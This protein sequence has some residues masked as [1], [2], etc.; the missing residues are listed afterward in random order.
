MSQDMLASRLSAKRTASFYVLNESALF[1]GALTIGGGAG[2]PAALLTAGLL[3]G[4]SW[5]TAAIG[6][7]LCGSF[8]G[9]HAALLFDQPG[10]L[11]ERK[12][13]REDLVGGLVSAFL[14][15]AAFVFTIGSTALGLQ[16][17][18]EGPYLQLVAWTVYVVILAFSL[19]GSGS[20]RYF[21]TVLIFLL[22]RNFSARPSKF[23]SW[24]RDA[25]LL[26]VTGATYQFRH[27]SYQRWLAKKA[28][29]VG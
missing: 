20:M 27:A 14:F 15:C 1:D 9:L 11:D 26:R 23:L 6:S 8:I 13:I 16:G 28:P 3:V 5:W 29:A 19:F 25:G 22:R 24:A 12:V 7:T 4:E 21:C 10:A 17:W 2:A 18:T